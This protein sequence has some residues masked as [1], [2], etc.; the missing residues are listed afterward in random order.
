SQMYA[1]LANAEGGVAAV[2]RYAPE[3]TI[4]DET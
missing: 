3:A 2:K 4:S 1:S